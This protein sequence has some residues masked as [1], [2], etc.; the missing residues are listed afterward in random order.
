MLGIILYN[1]NNRMVKVATEKLQLL[2]VSCFLL[3]VSAKGQSFRQPI[4]KIIPHSP[5][6]AEYTKTNHTNNHQLCKNFGWFVTE[7]KKKNKEVQLNKNKSFEVWTFT[8][9]SIFSFLSKKEQRIISKFRTW[10]RQR[11]CPDDIIRYLFR[12]PNEDGTWVFS[13]TSQ[14]TLFLLSSIT[15]I[16]EIRTNGINSIRR[17]YVLS[18]PI[19][20]GKKLSRFYL[21]CDL[22]LQLHLLI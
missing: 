4:A 2:F 7:E 1:N 14:K 5:S 9:F 15:T 13:I 20:S 21:L 3:L 10:I 17:R 16:Q 6:I 18:F 12:H 11:I 19:C 8:L 22:S